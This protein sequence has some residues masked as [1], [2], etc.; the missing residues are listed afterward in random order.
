MILIVTNS[1][2]PTV[3]FAE[4]KFQ[5]LGVKYYRLNTDLFFTN[6]VHEV[7]IGEAVDTDRIVMSND[8]MQFRFED[9]SGVWYRRPVTPL[10]PDNVFSAQA[11]KYTEEEGD[12]FIRSIWKLLENCKWVSNPQAINA[13]GSKLHQLKIARQIGFTIPKSLAT[14][15]P[16]AAKRFYDECKGQVIVKPFK[17]NVVEYGNEIAVI[18]T[19]R[20]SQE[21][22]QHIDQ[23]R[24][25]ITFFQEEVAKQYEVRVTVIGDEIFTAKI[26]SQSDVRRALDWRRTS[27]QKA[28]WVYG[29]IPDIVKNR[30]KQMVSHYGLNYG[31]FDFAVNS[32]GEHVFFELNPNGQWAWQE[33]ELGYP[34]TKSLAK[35]LGD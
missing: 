10:L 13:A 30:C 23:V 7:F 1:S 34:M 32:E 9:V 18:Y 24:K 17:S 35:A 15:D 4:T 14:T 2:D 3:D 20:V 31:A 8:G 27:P 16:E 19:S 25:A 22:I 26:E 5:E 11:K 33:I 29:D 21:D 12:Y 6:F 28:T